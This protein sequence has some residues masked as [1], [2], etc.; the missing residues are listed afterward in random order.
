MMALG[1]IAALL[2]ATLYAPL[3]H[4]HSHGG[5]AQLLHAHLP[6][7]AIAEDESVVHME[8]PHSHADARSIDLLITTV[9]PL[10]QFDAVILT[11]AVI[12]SPTQPCCGFVSIDAP[13]A[14][15]PP[16]AR[17]RIPRAPPA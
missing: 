11:S 1:A 6:D 2:V 16:S 15:A 8:P 4:L 14:H 3:F 12:P 7:L 5:E 13:R 17:S 9:A 10:I